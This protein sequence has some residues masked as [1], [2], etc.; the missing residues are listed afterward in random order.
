MTARIR[1]GTQGWNY[2]AWVGPFYPEGTRA[3]DYL[4]V[5][6]RAFDTVEID[7]TFYAIPSAKVVRG[8]ASRVPDGFAFALK[9]PQAV[10]HEQRLRGDAI[11]IANR[12]FD[13][14]RELGPKLGPILIQMG[15][16][17]APAE[18]GA[19]RE[20]LPLLPNDLRLAIEFRQK[21][22]LR[23]DICALLT[24][25]QVALALSDGRW[26]P[27][28]QLLALAERP[29]G[30]FAYLRWMG[31][32]RT[33]VDY[34]HIQVDR[35]EELATWSAAVKALAVRLPSVYG[36]VNNHFAGHSPASVRELA[37]LLGL[38]VVEPRQ[39]GDQMTLF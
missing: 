11:D 20:F 31:P 33:L 34:S 37:R 36:Y 15:P 14:A 19:L 6:A 39:L 3:S 21:G 26:M 28:Q 27:R 12:F 24:E 16:G 17:F 13:V 2:D 4:G 8:W 25:H 38:P 18:E 5:Y 1:L 7:S 32:D 22:W 35:S 23:D 9:L 29:T 10:T 30:S